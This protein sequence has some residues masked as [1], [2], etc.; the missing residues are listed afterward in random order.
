MMRSFL[1]FGV[2]G[3]IAT[4]FLHAYFDVFSGLIQTYIF[5][6][7]A[8]FFLSEQVAPEE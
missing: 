3:Y 5:F 6:T 4:P 8:S 2:L 7:L 1:P